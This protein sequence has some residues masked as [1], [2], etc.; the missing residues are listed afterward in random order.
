LATST[1]Y[2]GSDP[3]SNLGKLYKSSD[4]G[5]NWI[6]VGFP[7]L[8][9][10]PLSVLSLAIAVNPV[11]L[12]ETIYAGTDAGGVYFSIDNGVTWNP[13]GSGQTD[14]GL[15][16]NLGA[17]VLAID[18]ATTTTVYAGFDGWSGGS[19]IGAVFKSVD[20]GANWIEI[21]GN[22]PIISP[23]HTLAINPMNTGILYVGF[24]GGGAFTSGDGGQ[25]WTDFNSGLSD[26]YVHSIA[27]NPVTPTT[28]YA[29]TC[30]AGVF[31]MQSSSD[32]PSGISPSKLFAVGAATG[33]GEFFSR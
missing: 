5:Q 23:V 29:G 2:A 9:S 26:P 21:D 27:I 31:V 16:T 14:F 30:N 10:S 3:A 22:L 19:E 6:D 13:A 11:T 28:M 20:G 25:T 18:P 33:K 15:P 1:I 17:S 32:P 12:S 8:P 7:T 4:G 24:W